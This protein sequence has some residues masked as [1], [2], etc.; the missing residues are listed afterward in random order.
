MYHL[1]WSL[2]FVPI[3]PNL[4]ISFCTKSSLDEACVEERG[5][6]VECF[7]L[8]EAGIVNETRAASPL[9]DTTAV[10]K[11]RAPGDLFIGAKGNKALESVD[12]DGGGG[13]RP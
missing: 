3:L 13:G 5:S 7:E 1:S 6:K 9:D 2:G 4:S 10:W 12:G 11:L 8:V